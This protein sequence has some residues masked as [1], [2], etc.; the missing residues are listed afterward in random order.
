MP[1]GELSSFKTT[2]PVVEAEQFESLRSRFCPLAPV[3][4]CAGKQAQS[5]DSGKLSA[6][7]AAKGHVFLALCGERTVYIMLD[8]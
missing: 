2:A 7:K 4:F 6:T 5:Q 8:L 3:C 1:K